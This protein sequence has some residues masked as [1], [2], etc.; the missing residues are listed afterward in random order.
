MSD[1]GYTGFLVG[2]G[3][4]TVGPHDKVHGKAHDPERVILNLETRE[5]KQEFD[6]IRGLGAHVVAEPYQM[7]GAWIATLEDPDGNYFQLMTPWEE[8]SQGQ[9][10]MN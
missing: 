3:F 9:Q 2:N 10:S 4:I 6:R 8:T 1:G 5:V 7:E